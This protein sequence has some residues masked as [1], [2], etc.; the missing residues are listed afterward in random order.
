MAAMHPFCKYAPQNDILPEQMYYKFSQLAMID[1]GTQSTIGA[2]CGLAR[3][4]PQW[5]GV[6]GLFSKS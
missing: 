6:L 5:P 3:G 4:N 1:L 2:C